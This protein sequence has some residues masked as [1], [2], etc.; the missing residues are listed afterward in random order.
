M[1]NISKLPL[2]VCVSECSM[3]KFSMVKFSEVPGPTAIPWISPWP[4]AMA[5]FMSVL[6]GWLTQLEYN[7]YIYIYTCICVCMYV[8]I[9]IHMQYKYDIC[10]CMYVYIYITIY[11]YNQSQRNTHA[12]TSKAQRNSQMGRARIILWIAAPPA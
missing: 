4:Q 10:M 6:Q 3:V 1:I 8:Y 12:H 7:V 11:I 2:A 9:Y 5:D